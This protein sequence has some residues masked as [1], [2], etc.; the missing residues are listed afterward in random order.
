[1]LR[2]DSSH[3]VAMTARERRLPNKR[4]E[5]L[6]RLEL[7]QI[8][9]VGREEFIERHL[10]IGQSL[11]QQISRER[12][13]DVAVLCQTVGPRIVAEDLLLLLHR[14]AEPGEADFVRRQIF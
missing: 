11:L 12:L 1:M 2:K 9:S 5:R 8:Q 6:E 10:P 4:L 13:D 14:S 3:S 7:L